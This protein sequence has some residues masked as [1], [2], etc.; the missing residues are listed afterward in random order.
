MDSDEGPSWVLV[1]RWRRGTNYPDLPLAVQHHQRVL[2]G[3]MAGSQRKQRF[4]PSATFLRLLL[5]H[6][7]KKEDKQ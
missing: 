5:D 2:M 3:N 1:V 6:G 4:R 7:N